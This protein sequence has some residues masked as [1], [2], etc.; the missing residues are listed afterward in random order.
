MTDIDALRQRI[1]ALDEQLVTL[2]NERAGCAL[3]I[4][5]RKEEMGLPIYQPTRE[6]EVL[7]RVRAVNHGPLDDGAVT[8]LFERIIDE[9]R[10]LE[11]LAKAKG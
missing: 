1:D 11:R 9:A 10:R 5:Q 3:L 2:L 7:A 6:A 4:G 8:R